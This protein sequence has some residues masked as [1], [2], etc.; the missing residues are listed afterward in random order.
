MSDVRDVREKRGPSLADST[1]WVD[2]DV[3]AGE[4]RQKVKDAAGRYHLAEPATLE[5]FRQGFGLLEETF[6]PTGEI[7]TAEMLERW[8]LSGSLKAPGEQDRAGIRAHYHMVLARDT[9]GHIAGVRDCFVTVDER[10]TAPPGGCA[11]VLMSHSLVLPEHRR[12]GVAALLR[13]VPIA[14][15]RLQL[16]RARMGAGREQA[17]DQQTGRL[18]GQDAQILLFAEMDQVV[19]ADRITVI[20]LLAYGKAGFRVVPPAVLPFAQPDFR[21]EVQHGDVE[22]CPLPFLCVVRQVGDDDATNIAPERLRDVVEHALA[23]HRCHA[24]QDHLDVIRDHALHAL[25]AQ[26][27]GPVPLL[28]LPSGPQE[29]ARLAPLLRAVTFPLYPK[30]WRGDEPL[31]EP[32]SELAA[33]IAEWR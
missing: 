10:P 3:Y 14:L 32:A 4:G 11:H 30:T 33:L 25:D 9:D 5:E 24:R 2:A 13:H 12:T 16:E 15:A 20:R 7:E 19:A 8:F 29:I 17:G 23:V 18:A 26:G 1:H 28:Q 21:D 31:A 22:P 6:G 27:T